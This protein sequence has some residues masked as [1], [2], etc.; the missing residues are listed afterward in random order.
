MFRYVSVCQGGSPGI[1]EDSVKVDRRGSV[2]IRYVS[3]RRGSVRI[4]SR[5][6][7]GDQ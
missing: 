1:G 7:T 5:W 3:D 6:I 4:R 2:R